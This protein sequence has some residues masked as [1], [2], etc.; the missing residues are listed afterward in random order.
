M[1]DNAR[2]SSPAIHL[3]PL[4]ILKLTLPTI[5]IFSLAG[6]WRKVYKEVGNSPLGGGGAS[7]KGC[8]IYDKY[9]VL[10]DQS[11]T[12]IDVRNLQG[13]THAFHAGKKGRKWDI[14]AQNVPDT[15][16]ERMKEDSSRRTWYKL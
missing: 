3:V 1:T 9:L 10:S 12:K 11:G 14:G 15:E 4:P 16:Y 6:R 2:A 13:K 7:R 8:H 5:E